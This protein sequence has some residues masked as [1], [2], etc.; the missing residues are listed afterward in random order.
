M[1]SEGVGG[2]RGARKDFV[3]GAGRAKED[4]AGGAREDVGGVV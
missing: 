1:E 3:G 2:V 4:V